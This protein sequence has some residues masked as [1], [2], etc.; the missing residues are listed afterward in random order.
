LAPAGILLK[1]NEGRALG[2]DR[3]RLAL[4][5]SARQNQ[6]VP[7]ASHASSSP[8]S[9][10]KP[11]IT[12]LTDFGTADGYVAAMKAVILR[13]L[14][15]CHLVDISHEVPPG[16]IATGAF[17]LGEVAGE[18]P[19]DTVHLVVVDPGVGST[20]RRIAVRSESGFFVGPD[21]GVLDPV[22]TGSEIRSI[23][24]EDL[25]KPRHGR[26]FDGR[27]RFAPAAA[28]LAMGEPFGRLGPTVRDPVRLDGPSPEKTADG[29]RGRVIH[30]DRFG[31][32][33]TN[34]PSRWVE[35]VL[36]GTEWTLTVPGEIN[37]PTVRFVSHYSDLPPGQA[38]IL[39][40]S[41]G[42]L[43]FALRDDAF[44]ERWPAVI[45]KEIF[46]PIR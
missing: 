38:G 18:F 6:R 40:S 20:R 21:N 44:A 17:L 13:L 12:L 15:E 26:T 43:E 29:V 33:I 8:P 10:P 31:N 42:T 28:A 34:L 35:G 46:L 3:H 24:R 1:Y 22:L 32:A 36:S 7:T 30:V 41:T 45:K 19:K 4:I 23:E 9:G 39:P 25:R 5:E 14:S 37:P 11:I 16:A 2:T 27:D